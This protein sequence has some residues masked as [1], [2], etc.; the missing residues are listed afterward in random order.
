M[1]VCVCVR[2]S[3][4]LWSSS[5]TTVAFVSF[6][7]LSF[8]RSVCLNERAKDSELMCVSFPPVLWQRWA[9]G[10]QSERLLMVAQ[11]VPQLWLSVLLLLLLS[12]WLFVL[13][14]FAFRSKTLMVFRLAVWAVAASGGCI[15]TMTLRV[16]LRGVHSTFFRSFLGP[17]LSFFSLSRLSRRGLTRF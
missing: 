2:V 5:S 17:Q 12:W 11:M 9:C 7:F 10:K 16:S 4:S 3:L 15:H 8:S 13:F 1:C 6:L 14:R